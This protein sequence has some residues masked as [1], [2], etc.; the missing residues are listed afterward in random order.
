MKNNITETDNIFSRQDTKVIKGFAVFMM[1]LHHLWGFPGR[2][3]PDMLFKMSGVMIQ[4]TDRD[5]IVAIGLFGKICVPLFMFLGGYGLWNKM[6]KEYS[7]TK[8]IMRLYQ[9]LWK[10]AVI[11]IPIGL[12]AFAHQSEYMADI[13]FS[14]VFDDHSI[15]VVICN[16]LGISSQY[17]FEWW[18]FLPY[19]IAM[20]IGYI[21]ISVNKINNFWIDAFGVLVFDIITQNLFPA[22]VSI[23]PFS[24]L[25]QSFWFQKFFICDSFIPCFLMGVV[26]AKYN[27][28]IRLQKLYQKTFLTKAGKLAG[29]VLESL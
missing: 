15:S 6:Q 3:L 24:R 29:G 23:E 10:V 17:N 13:N 16:F 5:I 22:L 7:L 25:G 20:V 21:F 8:D 28:L 4:N 9:S 19:L 11:F 12:L 26:F 18:F 27:G 14:H 2:Y 1:L